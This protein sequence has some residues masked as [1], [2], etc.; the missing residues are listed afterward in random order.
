MRS[1]TPQSLLRITVDNNELFTI[2]YMSGPDRGKVAVTANGYNMGTLDM[3]SASYSRKSK[4][5]VLSN[6]PPS[7]PVKWQ[8]PTDRAMVIN[9]TS[10]NSSPVEISSIDS[11]Y[12]G[13]AYFTDIYFNPRHNLTW[14]FNAN[15]TTYADYYAAAVAAMQTW[16]NNTNLNLSEVTS[17]ADITINLT[18]WQ[19][20][21]LGRARR[22]VDGQSIPEPNDFPNITS[23]ELDL[24]TT[25]I[26]SSHNKQSLVLHEAGHCFS[27][28]HRID[29]TE[30]G[31]GV[32]YNYDN[33]DTQLSTRD[34]QLI[35]TRYP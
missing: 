12:V 34:I 22:L 13:G 2:H 1:T 21:A 5:Y 33:G 23:C 25:N 11:G 6:L 3:Y 32:M 18:T 16:S 14:K 4:T 7:A 35:N 30:W 24:H 27:L 17:N 19:G 31:Y 29:Y 20:P 26:N 28:G 15:K 8:L 10:L 9:V